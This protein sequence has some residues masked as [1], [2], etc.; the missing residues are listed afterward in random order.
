MDSVSIPNLSSPDTILVYLKLCV[1]NEELNAT[2]N[3][4]I[5][6]AF[7]KHEDYKTCGD[8]YIGVGRDWFANVLNMWTK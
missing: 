8:L 2:I 3:E 5:I 7:N 4:K 1:E 6:V